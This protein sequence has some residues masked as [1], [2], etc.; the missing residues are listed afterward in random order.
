M[1]VNAQVQAMLEMMGDVEI[2]PYSM[3][4][5]EIRTTLEMPPSRLPEVGQVE[6]R[7]VELNGQDIALR[8][9]TPAT[10]G[11][12]SLVVHFHGGG[13]VIG[14]L[15]SHDSACR[16][17]CNEAESVVVAVDYRLAPEAKY[18]A[19]VEDCYHAVRWAQ[20]NAPSFGADSNQLVVLGDSAGGNLAAAVCLMARDR[21]A[22]GQEAPVIRFQVPIYPVTNHNFNTK[23][24][25]DNAE[26]YFLTTEFM[27]WFWEQYLESDQQGQEP[28]ASP[29][30]GELSNLPP[31]LVIT[32]EYDPLR[33]EGEA[34]AERLLA[35]GV[36]TEL[37]RYAGQIHGFVGMFESIDDGRR[38]WQTI[39]AKIKQAVA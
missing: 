37:I 20:Q 18:P 11:P 14:G 33:D 38:A 28:Y 19:A 21:A 35:A 7:K 17:L 23:S 30:Q 36:R 3:T 24:Y 25:Q 4:V 6:D 31:A 15:D 13:F 10:A 32:A 5:A 34:Y 29:L 1:T 12:H 9:Y 22:A 8:I 2:D 26:G 39:A 27:R 16:L